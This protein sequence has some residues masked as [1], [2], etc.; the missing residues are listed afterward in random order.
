MLNS[1][2]PNTGDLV[3]RPPAP[4]E[5]VTKAEA[6]NKVERAFTFR[7]FMGISESSIN[8]SEIEIES[9]ELQKLLARVTRKY[10]GSTQ[11]R[12]TQMDAPYSRLIW[13]WNTAEQEAAIDDPT[14]SEEEQL[15]RVDLKNLLRIISTSSGDEMLDRYFKAKQNMEDCG[16]ITFETLWTI[17]PLGCHVVFRAAFSAEQVF[18]I[19]HCPARDVDEDERKFTVKAY[20]LDWDG[21]TFNRALYELSIEA[22]PDKKRITELTF[23][24]LSEYRSS[25]E[26]RDNI[27]QL[28][29]RLIARGKEFVRYCIAP[30]GQQT[31]RY[32]GL[33]YHQRRSGLF[34]SAYREDD[35]ES[36]ISRG[37]SSRDPLHPQDS[38][39]TTRVSI[40][41][42]HATM[43]K[44]TSKS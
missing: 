26:D 22:F 35:G 14:E 42:E 39:F 27:E 11:S 33:S 8:D 34:R 12:L 6:R 29:K 3:D 31:F 43:V 13:A 30:R 37:A 36:E 24:P 2:D 20:S 17:F 32:D 28:K 7:K 5:K 21:F 16:Q 4:L 25:D 10:I 15:A 44:L 41:L 19:Q 38:T 40:V 18:F 9:E 1:L 23:Y